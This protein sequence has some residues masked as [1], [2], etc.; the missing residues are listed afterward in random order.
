MT[1]QVTIQVH[2]SIFSTVSTALDTEAIQSLTG[3]TSDP[4]PPLRLDHTS[5][6]ATSTRFSLRGPA[7]VEVLRIGLVPHLSVITSLQGYNDKN[8]KNNNNNNNNNNNHFLRQALSSEALS[9]VWRNGSKLCVSM[10]D[11]RM[12]DK[13]Y[14][15][16]TWDKILHRPVPPPLEGQER[17]EKKEK[18]EGAL[19][20]QQA[21]GEHIK[22]MRIR[23]PTSAAVSPEIGSAIS[24]YSFPFLRDSE[25]N[26]LKCTLRK[27]HLEQSLSSKSHTGPG[28]EST[29]VGNFM[30]SST[31]TSEAVTSI[32]RIAS[33]SI[34]DH[35]PRHTIS[36]DTIKAIMTQ[37]HFNDVLF[38]VFVE[39]LR[40][41]TAHG[42]MNPILG[43][44][45]IAT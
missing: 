28:G 38:Q 5:D 41:L 12:Q 29:G 18:T 40:Q 16:D 6:P 8:K 24:Y 37:Q 21:Q 31:W 7:A 43:S 17:E 33:S 34:R 27:I 25:L 22:K 32:S 14:G 20:G 2:P 19:G 36:D 42:R 26:T 9:R 10:M 30:D 11:P 13:R 35:C 45:S 3:D 15:H 23:W 39:A 44:P 4:T 1:I